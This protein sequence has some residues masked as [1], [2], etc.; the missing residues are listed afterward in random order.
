MRFIQYCHISSTIFHVVLCP[1]CTYTKPSRCDCTGS[2]HLRAYMA[3]RHKSVPFVRMLILVNEDQEMASHR[4]FS[5]PTNRREIEKYAN[6]TCLRHICFPPWD[7]DASWCVLSEVKS[8]ECYG[9]GERFEKDILQSTKLSAI[10]K[11]SF[12]YRGDRGVR[13]RA[14]KNRERKSE[15]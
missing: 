8:Q 5:T 12:R 10:R 15:S 11:T 3:F 6:R 14:L 4:S 7:E 2:I 9:T 1:L 13:K